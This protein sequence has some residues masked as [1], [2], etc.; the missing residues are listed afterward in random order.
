MMHQAR[1]IAN[2]SLKPLAL[3]LALLTSGCSTTNYFGR[4][5]L[6]LSAAPKFVGGRGYAMYATTPNLTENIKQTMTELGMNAIHPV[7]EPNGGSGLE[8]TSADHRNVRVS[9]HSTGVRSTIGIKVGWLGDEPLSRSFLDQL[10]NLQGKLP[11]SALPDPEVEK[12]GM[13]SSRFAREAVPDNIMIR[14]QLDSSFNP[15]IAPTP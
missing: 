4:E 9:I 2:F 3:A 1:R 7:P 6:A 11:E 15:S 10:E 14:N 5:K 12:A 13:F 8:A